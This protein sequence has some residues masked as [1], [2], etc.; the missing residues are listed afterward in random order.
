MLARIRQQRSQVVGIDTTE[1]M[2]RDI[3]R[4]RRGSNLGGRVIARGSVETSQPR[5]T[6]E[7]HRGF[8]QNVS[9]LLHH[10]VGVLR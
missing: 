1:G 7:R 3:R 6:P 10:P 4:V 9:G 8:D 2:M 5:S